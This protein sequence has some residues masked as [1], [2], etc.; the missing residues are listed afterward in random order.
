MLGLARDYLAGGADPALHH[1]LRLDFHQLQRRHGSV[2]GI[3]V[4][5]PKLIPVVS[6]E[7]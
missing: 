3:V 7:W 1:F 4:P 2:A 6:G 5:R